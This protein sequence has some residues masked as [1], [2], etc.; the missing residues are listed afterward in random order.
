MKETKDRVERHL[1]HLKELNK[2]VKREMQKRKEKA[3]K[4]KM[5]KNK[6]E[7]TFE[8]VKIVKRLIE[9]DVYI[10]LLEESLQELERIS[11]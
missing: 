10:Q 6:K 11:E 7:M 4:I 8:N 1:N 3:F 5:G 9:S 2:T